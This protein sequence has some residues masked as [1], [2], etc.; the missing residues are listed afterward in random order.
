M[1]GE[2]IEKIDKQKHDCMTL[3]WKA[4]R[5]GNVKTFN[6]TFA[7]LY[8]KYTDDEVQQFIKGMGWGLGT[9]VNKRAGVL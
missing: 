9:A 5:T 2:E 3:I 7:D 1:T 6:D 4:Y 8:A